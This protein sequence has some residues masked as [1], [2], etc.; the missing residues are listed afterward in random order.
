M[1]A[2]L[3]RYKGPTD[4]RGSRIIATAEG[5]HRITIPYDYGAS[6]PHEVAAVALCRKLGWTGRLVSG[7]LPNGDTVWVF[8]HGTGVTVA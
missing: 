7:G 5:G 1:K 3:T 4:A 8:S 2:I 6:D